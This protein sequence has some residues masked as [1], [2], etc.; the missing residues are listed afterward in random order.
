MSTENPK[1]HLVIYCDA[2]TGPSNPGPTG[3]GIHGYVYKERDSKS[4]AGNTHFSPTESGYVEKSLLKQQGKD[5]KD[6]EVQIVEY[7]DANYSVGNPATNNIGETQAV[8]HSLQIAKD[9]EVS[10]VL[11]LS[12]SQLV[13]DS[14]TK[15]IYG[16][17]KNNWVTSTG[18]PVAN[19][20]LLIELDQLR[21][22]LVRSGVKVEFKKVKGHAG[23]L[24]NERADM[25]ALIARFK[26]N[27]G[28]VTSVFKRSP[29]QRYWRTE[30]EK[31]PLLHHNNIYF[32]SPERGLDSNTY[33]TG[34]H[35]KLDIDIGAKDTTSSFA[36]VTIDER[37]PVID[38]VLGNVKALI[39]SRRLMT[40]P[41]FRIRLDT[42][43]SS[44]FN[45]YY[46]LFGSDVVTPVKKNLINLNLVKYDDP[47][48]EES[49]PPYLS[50][51][52][53]KDLEDLHFKF[54]LYKKKDPLVIV[55]DITD[56]L[57]E[58]VE[59]GKAHVTQL[60]PEFKTGARR[61]TLPVMYAS[62]EKQRE[63]MIALLF[64][65][66]MPT[67]NVY[68]R[69]EQLNP[70]VEVI[71]WAETDSLFRYAVIIH[72]DGASGIW[73]NIYSNYRFTKLDSVSNSII[74]EYEDGQQITI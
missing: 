1:T 68:K 12:D 16:W 46:N 35:G 24:G 5:Y 51:D 6:V 20:E 3:A 67:R 41:F 32:S 19:K 7:I 22:E 69:L 17:K 50:F 47:V 60:R 61:L 66:G 74:V 43:F 42:L 58:C 38:D 23:E 65:I 27:R 33:F 9:L 18:K 2:A 40:E 8:I 53:I 72:V 39:E 63:A 70:K 45:D 56:H 4:Y 28:D 44:K 37:D 64:G 57:Y 62:K 55:T 34:T 54:E 31:H 25:F 49:N 36:I 73:S 26:T 48:V 14:I 71:T 10:S 11:V 13:L 59:K 29:A 52:L 15:W 30:V 21:N